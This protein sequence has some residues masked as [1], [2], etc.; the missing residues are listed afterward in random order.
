M[1][2]VDERPLAGRL[3]GWM[4]VVGSIG[5]TLLPLLPGVEGAVITPT[6]ER[7]C[8]SSRAVFAFTPM[9]QCSRNVVTAAV[10]Y[11]RFSNSTCAM[12]GTNALSCNCPA[13]AA[14]VSVTS[15]PATANAT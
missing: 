1:D 5:A 7:E 9:T 14:M 4:F 11:L 8:C 10:R 2:V 12:T 6:N 15:P 3:V 13:S